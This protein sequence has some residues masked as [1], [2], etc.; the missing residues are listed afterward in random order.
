MSKFDIKNLK[1]Q[2]KESE[3]E[4]KFH[5]QEHDSKSRLEITKLFLK[6]YFWLIAGSFL[7]CLVY[8]YGAA[9]LNFEF[10]LETPIRFIDVSNTVSIITTTLS[11]G[12]GFVIGYYFKNKE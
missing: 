12:M 3:P 6:S 7:F 9:Y 8:N 2:V 5:Q 1:E 11:S 4:S 10:K